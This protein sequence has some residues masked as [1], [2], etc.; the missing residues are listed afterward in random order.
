[1]LHITS[2]IDDSQ[3][4]LHKKKDKVNQSGVNEQ[5]MMSCQLHGFSS[6]QGRQLMGIFFVVRQ[7]HWMSMPINTMKCILILILPRHLLQIFAKFLLKCTACPHLLKLLQ[8][9]THA[10]IQI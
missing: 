7:V 2:R 9:I 1:M 8:N 4:Y 5:K 3:S 10:P 6:R